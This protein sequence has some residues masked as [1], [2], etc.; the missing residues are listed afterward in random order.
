MV[1]VVLIK[2]LL[3][4][5]KH[6]TLSPEGCSIPIFSCSIEPIAEVHCACKL[7]SDVN[8]VAH[9]R[10]TFCACAYTHTHTHTQ[11]SVAPVDYGNLTNFCLG[12]FNNDVRQLSFN[13]SIAND[14]IPE[15]AEMFIVSLTLDSAAQD[16]LDNR[17]TVSPDVAT[18]TIQDD[19]GKL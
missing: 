8:K 16:R 18:V 10:F 13:V 2:T 5:V 7:K 12:P 14:N 9:W 15:D 1:L 3:H 19:D 6:Y 11:P 4:A 17:V